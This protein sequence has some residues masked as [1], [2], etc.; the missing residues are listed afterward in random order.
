ME[1]VK[2][3][4]WTINTHQNVADVLQEHNIDVKGGDIDAV[5]WSHSHL[6]HTGD[7]TT[8]PK[9]TRLVVG[10]DFGQTFIPAYPHD[11]ASTIWQHDFEGRD[12]QEIKFDEALRIGQFEAH[13]FFGDGSFYLLDT[14]G[15]LVSHMCGLARTTASP[16]TFVLLG[17]D[18]AHH[19]GQIRPSSF[20]PLPAAMSPPSIPQSKP[21]GSA[22]TSEDNNGNQARY[23]PFLEPCLGVYQDIEASKKSI[24]G[25]QQF[26]GAD[27]VLILLAHDT[28]IEGVIK[29]FPH[30]LNDWKQQG[31]RETIR[32]S[33]IHK[34]KVVKTSD[35]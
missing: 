3:N 35:E 29:T 2:K 9:S 19:A 18:I 8:F 25:L 32:W 1:A 30:A 26:D 10:R 22:Q 14:P 31:Y 23:T 27:D 15:H 5:I 34:L 13:D 16:P 33:S 28:S 4:G 12:L 7:V 24:C 6:D 21:S 11:P 20:S 17:G